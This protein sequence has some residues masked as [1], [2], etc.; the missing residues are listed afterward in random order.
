[1][2]HA[3]INGHNG[4]VCPKT[5]PHFPLTDSAIESIVFRAKN[6]L[7]EKKGLITRA[8]DD[9]SDALHFAQDNPGNF[10]GAA[11]NAGLKEDAKKKAILLR[12]TLSPLLDKLSA[13]IDAKDFHGIDKYMAEIERAEDAISAPTEAQIRAAAQGM[14][15]LFEKEKQRPRDRPIIDD[16]L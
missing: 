10:S 12:D 11:F 8:V 16:R 5:K 2:V 14:L 4:K 6:F 1:M 15:D 7:T 9:Y 13:A 3:S